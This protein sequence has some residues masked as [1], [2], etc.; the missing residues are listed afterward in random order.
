[1]G[2]SGHLLSNLLLF[3]R[4]L[5]GVGLDGT[6][7]LGPVLEPAKIAHVTI[8]EILE[9]LARQRGAA[10]GCAIDDHGPVRAEVGIVIGRSRVRAKLEHAARDVL[11]ALDL[12]GSLQLRR[13][14][15]VDHER[16]A[17]CD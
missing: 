4:V 13:I 11:G 16:L 17:V 6:P 12:A 10:T 9:R 15:H 2:E 14:P 5:H 8:A 7:A 1:M 3:G